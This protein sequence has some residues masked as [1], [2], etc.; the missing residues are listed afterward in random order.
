M[1]GVKFNWGRI[2]H[3]LNSAACIARRTCFAIGSQCVL[4]FSSVHLGNLHG[5][6]RFLAQFQL[7]MLR[8][9]LVRLLFQCGSRSSES[10]TFRLRGF[11]LWLCCRNYSTGC[12][13]L[14]SRSA[15]IDGNTV[16]TRSQDVTGGHRRSSDRLGNTP[17]LTSTGFRLKL[18]HFSHFTHLDFGL[19]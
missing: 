9:K 17:A 14:R 18:S 8:A 12:D 4:N 5:E 15:R 10:C 19:L 7:Q 2:L 3:L 13:E 1:F 6:T 11:A 16:T